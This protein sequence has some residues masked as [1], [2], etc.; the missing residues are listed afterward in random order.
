MGEELGG[1]LNIGSIF[2]SGLD[3]SV[4]LSDKLFG[5]SFLYMLILLCWVRE[6]DSSHMAGAR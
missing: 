1:N 6:I 2:S 4:G 5:C 3:A